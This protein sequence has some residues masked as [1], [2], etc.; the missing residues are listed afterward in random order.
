[1]LNNSEY[2]ILCLGDVVGEDAVAKIRS[3]LPKY[4]K[5]NKINCV[6][7]NGENALMGKGNGISPS[8][9]EELF[10]SGVDVITGGNHS[11]ASSSIYSMLDESRFII[12]PANLHSSCPG[13]GSTVADIDGKKILVLN[14]I[15]RIY[16]SNSALDP[17]A[18]IEKILEKNKGKYD[19]SVLDIHAE[20]TSE[21]FCIASE[22]DGRIDII[23]GTHT[24]VPTADLRILPKGSAY[25]TDLGMCG[26]ENSSL[27]V[28]PEIAIKKIKTDMPV[29]FELSRNP[30]ALEGA[31]FTFTESKLC[32]LH[33]IRI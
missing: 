9:A 23:F 24:H 1:M 3:T 28:K 32:D 21:K 2:K 15:G 16:M 12:R 13:F 7:V 18:E 5:D 17:F 26:P 25:I 11:F 4:I 14:V 19:L 10:Y 22:F 27:G 33:Q 30:I 20:A 29:R 8:I 6:I 31:I